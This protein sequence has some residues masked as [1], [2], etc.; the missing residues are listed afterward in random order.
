MDF[1]A[2]KMGKWKRNGFEA[3]VL[4]FA[5][6][7]AAW[8]GALW[9]LVESTAFLQAARRTLPSTLLHELH[10]NRSFTFHTPMPGYEPGL[11]ARRHGKVSLG[12]G[13][14]LGRLRG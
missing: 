10:Q 1:T 14:D 12:I 7:P 2:C 4:V 9:A 5:Q 3:S 13:L 6:E 11:S 8:P